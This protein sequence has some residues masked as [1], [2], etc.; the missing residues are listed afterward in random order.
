MKIGRTISLRLLVILQVD[1]SLIEILRGF[2]QEI[3]SYL[4]PKQALF[5]AVFR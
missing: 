2:I 4:P 3:C 1:N 5:P